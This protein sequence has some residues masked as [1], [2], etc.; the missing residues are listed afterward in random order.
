MVDRS[1]KIPSG[2]LRINGAGG[3]TV[4]EMRE[5]LQALD[6]SY[7]AVARVE[8]SAQA[9]LVAT[10]AIVRYER[11]FRYLPPPWSFPNQVSQGAMA[12][13][14]LVVNRVVLESPGFWEFVGA[15]NPLEVLRKYLNDRHERRKDRE[16]R[17]G[18]ERRQLEIE[19]A[20]GELEVLRR[21]ADLE[22]EF[23]PEAIPD[24]LRLRILAA[25]VREPLEELSSL[26]RRG[27]IDGGSATAGQEL[28]PREEPPTRP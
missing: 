27:L 17:E 21:I 14:P 7:Q 22:R 28:P 24:G 16:Y 6:A 20:L 18:A 3:C 10:E 23:G 25:E 12:A 26:D 8:L 5:L 9:A 11:P 13:E 2:L 15:L 1:P 19:N 4:K